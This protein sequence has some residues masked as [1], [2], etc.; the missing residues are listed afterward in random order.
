MKILPAAAVGRMDGW[1]DRHDEASSL[2]SQFWK[3]SKFPE[4]LFVNLLYRF[5]ITSP[6]T[7]AGETVSNV[8]KNQNLENVPKL[9]FKLLSI[10]TNYNFSYQNTF[11]SDMLSNMKNSSEK[12]LANVEI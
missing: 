5:T 11:K 8:I 2:F 10:S 7:L 3:H 9:D 12:Y 1:R 6:D 4:T